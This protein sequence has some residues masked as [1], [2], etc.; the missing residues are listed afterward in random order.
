MAETEITGFAAVE[1]VLGGFRAV[2]PATP[3]WLVEPET[4]QSLRVDRL[5]PELDIVVQ[6]NESSTMV[7]SA[8]TAHHEILTDLCRQ[9]GFTLLVVDANGAVPAQTLATMRTGLSTAARRVAQQAGAREAKVDLMPRIAAAKATCLRLLEAT[10]GASIGVT[11]AAMTGITAAVATQATTAVTTELPPGFRVGRWQL[12]RRRAQANLR[13]FRADWRAFTENRLAVFGLVLIALFGLMSIAHPILRATVWQHS[14]YEPVTG[15]D[16][17][18]LH[19][20]LPSRQHLLGTDSLGRDVLSMLLAATTPTFI[21]GIIAAL[22]TAAIG[23]AI[24]VVSAY[25]RG[26]VDSIFTNISN[27]FLLVPAPLFMVIVG[28]RYTEIGPVPLGLIYGLI[29]GAGGAAI[30]LRSQALQV[31]V[32]PFIDVARIAGGGSRRIMMVHVV[33]H[34]LPLAALYMMLAVTG[35]VVADAFISFFGFTRSYL[36][37]GTIIYSSFVYS[38]YLAGGV[39]WHVLIPPSIALSLFAAA[40]YFVGRGLHEVADP[41]L[42]A[43]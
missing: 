5:Y 11:D 23:T 8:A 25:R 18:V 30:V 28:M 41:R 4:G 10:S 32:K 17:M 2:A 33:P 1:E 7:R 34:M 6:F 40:F 16:M 36:N 21:V 42:R 22:T 12:W 20:A 13:R 26:A 14:M 43:R 29:A 3:A 27:A 9:A 31:V 35:A 37:W 24:G 19:P 15:Y 38:S 39:E